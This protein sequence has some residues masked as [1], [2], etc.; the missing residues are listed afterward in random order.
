M[1]DDESTEQKALVRLRS[2]IIPLRKLLEATARQAHLFDEV[3]CYMPSKDRQLMGIPGNL[4]KAWLHLIMFMVC[5]Q[6]IGQ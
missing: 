1:E 3:L 2:R 5:H 4:A 6:V